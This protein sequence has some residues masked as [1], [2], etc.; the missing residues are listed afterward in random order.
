MIFVL[1]C[2]ISYRTLSLGYHLKLCRL[3]LFIPKNIKYRSYNDES[4]QFN[5]QFSIDLSYI[6]SNFTSIDEETKIIARPKDFY[7]NRLITTSIST[8]IGIFF[9]DCLAQFTKIVII[10]KYITDNIF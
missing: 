9:S 10:V 7:L 1:F 6:S 4:I 5:D 8:S 2:F 3:N